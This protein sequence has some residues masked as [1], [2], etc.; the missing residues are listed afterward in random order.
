MIFKIDQDA[1]LSDRAVGIPTTPPSGVSFMDRDFGAAIPEAPAYMPPSPESAGLLSE[2][3]KGW[4][5]GKIGLRQTGL[6][7]KALAGDVIGSETMVSEA[8]AGME[9]LTAEGEPYA[10][11]VPSYTGVKDIYSGLQYLTGGIS[12]NALNMLVS[13]IGGGIGGVAGRILV[14]ATLKKA[15][16]D[17]I[18]KAI[19]NKAVERGAIS[20]AYAA[21]LGL[22]AGQIAQQQIEETG[23]VDTG[24]AMIGGA[25]AASL[26]VI[27]QWYLAKK[28][29]LFGPGHEFVGGWLKR[30]GK[31]AGT[32]AI[33]EGPTEAVQTIIENASVPGKDITTKESWDNVINAGIIGAALGVVSGGLVTPKG[34]KTTAAPTPAAIPTA[35]APAVTPE[36]KPN[37]ITINGQTTD[38]E[39]DLFVVTQFGLNIAKGADIKD[40]NGK[41]PIDV[42]T[43]IKN[44]YQRV[45]AANKINAIPEE[46]QNEVTDQSQ[47][48]V[49]RWLK[50]N[51]KNTI[52]PTTIEEDQAK[53]IKAGVVKPAAPITSA[54]IAKAVE[55][56]ES[57]GGLTPEGLLKFQ[58]LVQALP[59]TQEQILPETPTS[60][61]VT[62][63]GEGV[64][65]QRAQLIRAARGTKEAPVAP[66]VVSANEFTKK[67]IYGHATAPRNVV[68]NKETGEQFEIMSHDTQK[69]GQGKGK[70]KIEK[71]V[72]ISIRPLLNLP[73]AGGPEGM[74][75]TKGKKL[76][77]VEAL[78]RQGE[79]ESGIRLRPTPERIEEATVLRAVE[80]TLATGRVPATQE[81]KDVIRG[82][83][84]RRDLKITPASL[85]EDIRIDRR[86]TLQEVKEK[87]RVPIETPETAAG[88]K[89]VKFEDIVAANP[90]TADDLITLLAKKKSEGFDVSHII[91]ELA[92]VE[93]ITQEEEVTQPKAKDVPM[94]YKMPAKENLTGKD[95]TTLKLAEEGKRTSTTRSQALGKIGDI[96]TF[97]GKPQ[98]YEIIGRHTIT[99]EDIA[100]KKFIEA[101]S[102]TEQ[103]TVNAIRTRH[104]NQIKAGAVITHYE[105]IEKAKA[106]KRGEVVS[107]RTPDTFIPTYLKT[108]QEAYDKRIKKEKKGVSEI[109]GEKQ[110]AKPIPLTD[111]E[112][113]QKAGAGYTQD[114]TAQGYVAVT[115]RSDTG[116]EVPTLYDLLED[117]KNRAKELNAKYRLRGELQKN[118]LNRY[119]VNSTILDI[120]RKDGKGVRK[121]KKYVVVSKTTLHD[122]NVVVKGTKN[123]IKSIP[124]AF[125]Y[126]VFDT[127]LEGSKS[128]SMEFV[129]DVLIPW[130]EATL[131]HP[132]YS[133]YKLDPTPDMDAYLM[134]KQTRIPTIGKVHIAITNLLTRLEEAIDLNYKKV[135]APAQI[136]EGKGGKMKVHLDPAA[137]LVLK[138]EDQIVWRDSWLPLSE[139]FGEKGILDALVTSEDGWAALKKFDQEH[140]MPGKKGKFKT[141]LT[142]EL[143]ALQEEEAAGAILKSK[144]RLREHLAGVAKPIKTEA[145]TREEE[146]AQ[147]A[148]ERISEPK[149]IRR[150]ILELSRATK[151]Q[152]LIIAAEKAGLL[153]ETQH[154]A[155][156][157][158][159]MLSKEGRQWIKE[160][161]A[162]VQDAIETVEEK[163]PIESFKTKKVYQDYLAQLERSFKALIKERAIFNVETNL[164]QLTMEDIP[165]L[166]KVHDI[167]IERNIAYIREREIEQGITPSPIDAYTAQVKEHLGVTEEA[168]E[169]VPGVTIT[170]AKKEKAKGGKKLTKAQE[171]LNALIEEQTLDQEEFKIVT[172]RE[173]KPELTEAE[174]VIALDKLI[175]ESKRQSELETAGLT[176]EQIF[177][178]EVSD[179]NPDE[180][181]YGYA[182]T[183][184]LN[185]AIDGIHATSDYVADT[186]PSSTFQEFKLSM[187]EF[188]G[189]TWDKIKSLAKY[190]WDRILFM[191]GLSL[192]E[193]PPKYSET[194]T[195]KERFP[196]GIRNNP[197][198]MWKYIQK[199]AKSKTTIY[200]ANYRSTGQL[201]SKIMAEKW[202]YISGF[203]VL[204]ES[205]N[206]ARYT[207]EFDLMVFNNFAWP[208]KRNPGL[209]A[210][211]KSEAL[212]QV[213]PKSGYIEKGIS[214]Y[215]SGAAVQDKNGKFSIIAFNKLKKEMIPKHFSPWMLAEADEV[216]FQKAKR[217]MLDIFRVMPRN[218]RERIILSDNWMAVNDNSD[219]RYVARKLTPNLQSFINSDI[220]LTTG[221]KFD[222]ETAFKNPKAF[223]G[224]I[225]VTV[226]SIPIN[227]N[228][229]RVETVPSVEIRIG[230]RYGNIYTFRKLEG[231]WYMAFPS[232]DEMFD[233]QVMN[234]L[235]EIDKADAEGL[236]IVETIPLK[237][238]IGQ[239]GFQTYIKALPYKERQRAI[240]NYHAAL[241]WA[242]RVGNLD[243]LGATNF[244]AMERMRMQFG[245]WK[246]ADGEW[247]YEIADDRVQWKDNIKPSVEGIKESNKTFKLGDIATINHLLPF[248]ANAKDISVVFTNLYGDN[249]KYTPESFGGPPNGLIEIEQKLKQNG[250][251]ETLI[252]ELQHFVQ[253]MEGT[254]FF[255]IL[256]ESSALIVAHAPR[257]ID[258]YNRI[259]KNPGDQTWTSK[260]RN[261]VQKMVRNPSAAVHTSIR[262]AI[263]HDLYEMTGYEY[264]SRI[265]VHRSTFTQGELRRI[266][267]PTYFD[268]LP[269]DLLTNQIFESTAIT[270]RLLEERLPAATVT[271]ID[272]IGRE[273]H[274]FFPSG[275]GFKVIDSKIEEVLN[276]D[277][278]TK[279]IILGKWNIEKG[280]GTG[281]MQ[282]AELSDA[283]RLISP[284]HTINHEIFHMVID[285]F[286]TKEEQATMLSK[287]SEKGDTEIDTW[288]RMAKS[289]TEWVDEAGRYTQPDPMQLSVFQKIQEN[290]K[291][292]LFWLK[293]LIFGERVKQYKTVES[294]F[295]AIHSGEITLRTPQLNLIEYKSPGY[296]RSMGKNALPVILIDK[297]GRRSISDPNLP[298]K[299]KLIAASTDPLFRS[300]AKFANS[301]TI[302]GN[303]PYDRN[304]I[305]AAKDFLYRDKAA[306]YK[307]GLVPLMKWYEHLFSNPL[308]KSSATIVDRNPNSTTFGQRILKYPAW[309][310]AK[311]IE[312]ERFHK[313]TN[314]GIEFVNSTPTYHRL[315]VPKMMGLDP[316][317]EHGTAISNKYFTE[318]ELRNPKI[319][320]KIYKET[321]S[322]LTNYVLDE[323]QIQ[324][325]L[326]VTK[327]MKDIMIPNLVKHAEETAIKPYMNTLTTKEY[328][329]LQRLYKSLLGG[330][331]S[332]NLM[333][334][335]KR[336]E[337][338][339]KD[340]LTGRKVNRLARAYKNLAKKLV[341]IRAE[342]AKTGFR[343]GYM[344]LRREPS[345]NYVSVKMIGED[346]AMQ[347]VRNYSAF[348]DAHADRIKEALLKNIPELADE[349]KY[350]VFIGRSTKPTDSTFFMVGD[351]NTTRII[352]LA[353]AKLT[354]GE[355]I[356]LEDAAELSDSIY[357]AVG[358]I[359]KARGAGIS[360]IHRKFA[361]FDGRLNTIEGY[362]KTDFRKILDGYVYGYYGM[363]S[364]FDAANRY[365]ESLKELKASAPAMYA[366]V[367]EYAKNNLRNMDKWDRRVGKIKGFM[368]HWYLAGKLSIMLLQITQNF[369][370]GIPLMAVRMREMGLKGGINP[371]RFMIGAMRDCQ[372]DHRLSQSEIE[373][374]SYFEKRGDTM[375]QFVRSIQIE[376][377]AT[378]SKMA[379][380]LLEKLAWPM[381]ASE[382]FNR[383]AAVLAYHRMLVQKAGYDP[384]T[385][386]DRLYKECEDFM[387]HTHWWYSRS[388]LPVSAHGP[389]EFARTANLLYTFRPFTH[390]Y[391][392]SLAYAFLNHG[393][394]GGLMYAARSFAWLAVVGGLPALPWIDDFI[395]LVEGWTGIPI[396]IKARHAV[397]KLAGKNAAKFT[398]AGLFGVLNMDISMALRPAG[399]PWP[400]GGKPTE[401]IFGVYS[402]MGQKFSRFVR[403]L[404]IGEYTRAI[405]SASPI[406]A[407][408]IFK[409]WRLYEQGVTTTAK[410]PIYLDG[411]VAKLG[412]IA[413]LEQAMGIKNYEYSI[414]MQDRWEKKVVI[415]HYADVKSRI[416]KRQHLAKTPEAR[417]DVR[418][419]M[420]EFNISIPPYLRGIVTPV[421]W[422]PLARPDRGMARFQA[423]MSKE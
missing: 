84:R 260:L 40:A 398:G 13:V 189:K 111:I 417:A 261:A 400:L 139:L 192:A 121:V 126:K 72:S 235:K 379:S 196:N 365:M 119:E 12:E 164:G 182:D 412:E 325:Y 46:I 347:L 226:K 172:K 159:R 118:Q 21:S 186:R 391:V 73:E 363:Q 26:D 334:T 138:P 408:N 175:D 34:I 356:S 146:Q 289:Y 47:K 94:Y 377:L 207:S 329:E 43:E 393:G 5:R 114:W 188:L 338:N 217:R 32:Q 59:P 17:V 200:A 253:D 243:K 11:A 252:H 135:G 397:E 150:E 223:T 385:D 311:D 221:V 344:P 420:L 326:E 209:Y 8:K 370:T 358:D 378:G 257:L 285:I 128:N 160:Q 66:T 298:A 83:L 274:V 230:G 295:S 375:A 411:K 306:M 15:A 198:A 278:S 167:W 120:P 162:E 421:E 301:A 367:S 9:T 232:L 144:E 3:G 76:E 93:T 39:E 423:A 320:E 276:S 97:E 263:L 24:R 259:I 267:F 214:P 355:K 50:D 211:V 250:A 117:A 294:F 332:R 202:S 195:G 78:Q 205:N 265:S 228:K 340:P 33:V 222:L 342:R 255:N 201:A 288:E 247:R 168:P 98:L 132:K 359:M 107:K 361:Q 96:V 44:R 248:Y 6:G 187:H 1:P 315:K 399:L 181:N 368:F 216:T 204:N 323:E 143:E 374:L 30:V 401:S 131:K 388:N 270:K 141:D 51:K 161:R 386:M 57:I 390:N 108:I 310:D 14:G 322:K 282:I 145:L 122:T 37:I 372:F 38:I 245:W 163:R 409:A 343:D 29:G 279:T 384:K 112:A 395:E 318:V 381:K 422:V 314:N 91:A 203:N 373:M 125:A 60:T 362:I 218:S 4:K 92:K 410:Q 54:E 313:N 406:M 227:A 275:Y 90:Q 269:R 174:A 193:T 225:Q 185:H 300:L 42:Y 233:P 246:N 27:P 351:M 105:K 262:E 360:A 65:E 346:G 345:S 115:H 129:R 77:R 287:F 286:A 312:M 123:R 147:L 101:L 330:H 219:L 36:R 22:E 208:T 251:R 100:S 110:Y 157:I 353:I 64:H 165:K 331:T 354:A 7:L 152:K 272:D 364:K 158:A 109:K 382:E 148:R 81:H 317:F 238:Q 171:T 266:P 237:M 291:Q 153:K 19:I 88:Q 75:K 240:D 20:G 407:E 71:L 394:T 79:I 55:T 70:K 41:I 396:R 156:Y 10:A 18:R 31:G 415:Q 220:S 389:S 212:R 321:K 264:E 241:D 333:E 350:E 371:E 404:Q 387:Y 302:D 357:H 87:V 402:G 328:A 414:L 82:I 213:F 130:I 149:R 102:Q 273:F 366:E 292:L 63:K 418:E 116:Q 16:T 283:A 58:E 419:R 134:G 242:N 239:F 349:S 52:G 62:R 231:T 335:L 339:T 25:L 307:H 142:E 258:S 392:L 49:A 169:G 297:K 327:F 284:T 416:V 304:A 124:L 268:K 179:I 35:T 178:Q 176:K 28:F 137:K 113:A 413:A 74:V 249:G 277:G 293:N 244:G 106:A 256:E 299:Q 136:V 341:D 316:V 68:I 281:L 352:D 154:T 2:A 224:A 191:R 170:T 369:L 236:G 85:T 104:K 280:L 89:R 23:D 177:N 45:K 184:G 234:V 86:T 383:R 151:L 229:G 53:G 197:L 95:T 319:I 180:E 133:N 271:Q 254:E 215:I 405:E 380:Q 103:W 127:K 296:M 337:F 308:W 206:R 48:D 190:L 69:V 336:K 305:E 210:K 309:A 80:E 199:V 61:E 166:L 376:T 290:A 348:S 155:P 99:T 56:K 303:I 324:S 67:Y 173:K 403:E 140:A 194:S 183:D